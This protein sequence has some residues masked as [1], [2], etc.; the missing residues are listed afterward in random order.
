M[1]PESAKYDGRFV[2]AFRKE[3]RRR[4]CPFYPESLWFDALR[5]ADLVEP[6]TSPLPKLGPI[7]PPKW[8]A[9]HEPR[10]SRD[11]DLMI[12]VQ[13]A[14]NR[15]WNKYGTYDPKWKS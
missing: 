11:Y 13:R 4:S 10:Y 6:C 2:S 12:S 7:L 9:V 15:W 14:C 3:L 8:I 5:C 1:A